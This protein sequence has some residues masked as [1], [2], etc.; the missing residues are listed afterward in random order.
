MGQVTIEG[1]GRRVYTFAEASHAPE[2]KERPS[3]DSDRLMTSPVWPTNDVV[4]WPV[5]ISHRALRARTPVDKHLINIRCNQGRV[6]LL[7]LAEIY[8]RFFMS[9]AK[10]KRQL[11]G[12]FSLASSYVAIATIATMSTAMF[13]RGCQYMQL[14]AFKHDRNYKKVLLSF[15]YIHYTKMSMLIRNLSKQ[16]HRTSPNTQV[17][18]LWVEQA[19][20]SKEISCSLVLVEFSLDLQWRTRS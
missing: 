7:W 2:T 11:P 15:W 14:I 17:T 13:G 19:K 8:A 18:M 5:S 6:L 20:P 9:I 10:S 12:D 16:K 4:C 3:G 1:K